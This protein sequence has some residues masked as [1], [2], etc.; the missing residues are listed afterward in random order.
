MLY[1]SSQSSYGTQTETSNQKRRLL[2]STISTNNNH[3]TKVILLLNPIEALQR[4]PMPHIN[5]MH[6]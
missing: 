4:I 3:E 6:M 1:R 2:L 5:F